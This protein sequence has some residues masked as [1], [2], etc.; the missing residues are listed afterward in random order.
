MG[1]I[2]LQVDQV[3]LKTLLTEGVRDLRGMADEKNIDVQLLLPAKLESIQADRDKLAV[4]VNNLI[5]NAIKYTP[6]DGNV[7]V[8]CQVK[9]DE[10]LITTKDNGIGIDPVDHA[11]RL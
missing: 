1:S 8:S 7:V 9:S 11:P 6:P 10:V 3:D 5:G 2:E 4:V